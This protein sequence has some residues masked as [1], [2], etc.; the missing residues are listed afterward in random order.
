MPLKVCLSLSLP[1]LSLFSVLKEGV[2]LLVGGVSRSKR[3]IIVISEGSL[4]ALC[5]WLRLVLSLFQ[6]LELVFS[7][8]FVF[9]SDF[10]H[11]QKL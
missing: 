5:L 10:F 6:G 11:G 1:H 9:K 3:R 7:Y 4:F 8:F 2:C